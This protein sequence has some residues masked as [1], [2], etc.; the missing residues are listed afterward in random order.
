MPHP[1]FVCRSGPVVRPPWFG[2]G[3]W[4]VRKAFVSP[5]VTTS[6]RFPGAGV[7]LTQSVG[8]T[9]K[10]FADCGKTEA[11]SSTRPSPAYGRCALL[12]G[13]ALTHAEYGYR[14]ARRNL[15]LCSECRFAISTS[16]HLNCVLYTQA[17][18]RVLP[19]GVLRSRGLTK[20]DA[21]RLSC[22]RFR[23]IH[24]DLLQRLRTGS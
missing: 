12:I 15:L 18:G 16:S 21:I 6:S 23:W 24:A 8:S 2:C 9:T 11:C 13:R 14:S 1:T 20:Q 3:C 5:F 10:K 7:S 19:P 4:S 22:R 17:S